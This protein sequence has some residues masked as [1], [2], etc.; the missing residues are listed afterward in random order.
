M[1]K[2]SGPVLVALKYAE[3]HF[4]SG[5]FIIINIIFLFLSSLPFLMPRNA[6]P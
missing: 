3:K 4:V 1:K 2:S 6:F 5:L